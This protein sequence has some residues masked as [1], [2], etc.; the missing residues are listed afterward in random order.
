MFLFI[1]TGS[2]RPTSSWPQRFD[3][4]CFGR[5]RGCARYPPLLSGSWHACI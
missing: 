2:L 4:N 1:W 3:G 5:R